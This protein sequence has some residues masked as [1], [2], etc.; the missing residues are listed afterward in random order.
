MSVTQN[1]QTARLAIGKRTGC[2]VYLGNPRRG[3]KGRHVVGD[4]QCDCGKTSAR[5]LSVIAALS[6]AFCGRGCPL[7]LKWNGKMHTKHGLA[8]GTDQITRKALTAWSAMKRRCYNPNDL[9]YHNY[10]GRG[11][12]VCDEWLKDVNAFVAHIGL[13]PSLGRTVSVDRIDNDGNYEPGNVHWVTSPKIQGRNKRTNRVIEAF[14]E[15][16]CLMEWAER[17]GLNR[18][19]ILNRLDAY[20]FSPEQALTIPLRGRRRCLGI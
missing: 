2:L 8:V 11:I 19:T 16:H 14:G 1:P 5:R 15:R 12:K 10:G 9:Q 18:A 3:Q 6:D 13:P 4:F 20:G 7:L 17:A